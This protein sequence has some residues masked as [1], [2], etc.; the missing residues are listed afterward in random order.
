MRPH[1]ATICAA[2]NGATCSAHLRICS[3]FPD[4]NRIIILWTS[5]P[6]LTSVGEPSTLVASTG[7]INDLRGD[8]P[9]TFRISLPIIRE[10]AQ[11]LFPHW[12]AELVPGSETAKLPG[13]YRFFCREVFRP[14]STDRYSSVG[15]FSPQ[16]FVCH[17]YPRW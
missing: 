1:F 4:Q 5:F 8:I 11:R 12:V 3:S 14:A 15:T 7:W 9:R 13:P 17:Y 6:P 10:S 2:I 16:L